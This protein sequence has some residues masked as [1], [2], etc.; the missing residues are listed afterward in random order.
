MTTMEVA[1][2]NSGFKVRKQTKRW[3]RVKGPKTV[4]IDCS[5]ECVKNAVF[6]VR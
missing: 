3:P 5:K 4:R 1:F 6:V 2:K